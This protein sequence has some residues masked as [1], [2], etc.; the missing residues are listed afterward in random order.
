MTANVSTSQ[1]AEYRR[2]QTELADEI[3]PEEALAAEEAFRRGRLALW[4]VA[5]GWLLLVLV[6]AWLQGSWLEAV[7]A[8]LAGGAVVVAGL[9]L[10]AR[11]RTPYA[12]RLLL[13][14]STVQVFVGKL[15]LSLYAHQSIN[16]LMVLFLMALFWWLG[17]LLD[18]SASA[19]GRL[20]RPRWG[21]AR[22]WIFA[23]VYSSVAFVIW[24]VDGLPAGAPFPFA[25]LVAAGLAAL[26]P[27]WPGPRVERD[28]PEL[29]PDAELLLKA[30]TK[31]WL[32]QL[33]GRT[34]ALLFAVFPL[35]LVL[36]HLG[37]Q[38][39]GMQ[40]PPDAVSS[41]TAGSDR[42]TVFWYWPRAL[43]GL[44]GKAVGRY[45]T[46]ADLGNTELF[47]VPVE[48]PTVAAALAK[49]TQN[50]KDAAAFA[51]L[52]GA[53]EPFR[54][55][56]AEDLVVQLPL[57][58]SGIA[59]RQLVQGRARPRLGHPEGEE[60]HFALENAL[61][62]LT[63][64]QIERLEQQLPF[65]QSLLVACGFFSFILLWRRGGDSPAA[66]WLALCLAGTA[67]VA[68]EPYIGLYLPAMMQSLWV[69]ALQS[70][71]RG[72]LL[73]A[74]SLLE[75]LAHT[76]ATACGLLFAGVLVIFCWPPAPESRR[77]GLAILGRI[78]LV[79]L[80]LTV[81]A[82]VGLL[83]GGFLTTFGVVS[84][85][86]GGVGTPG[87]LLCAVAAVVGGAWL[88]RRTPGRSEVPELGLLAG[89]AFFCFQ[90]TFWI[91]LLPLFDETLPAWSGWVGLGCVILFALLA[92]LLIV[93][94][95]FLHLAAG[96]DLGQVLLIAVL[97]VVFEQ[98]EGLSS[99]LMAD[100][101]FAS[102]A[103]K[104]VLGLLIV[105]ALFAPVQ[106]LLERYAAYLAVPGLRKIQKAVEGSLE[107][108]VGIGDAASVREAA[109]RFFADLEVAGALLYRR[110]A[111]GRL[112]RLLG[113]EEAPAVL[114]PSERLRSHLAGQDGAVIDLA[115]VYLNLRHFFLQHELARLE[116]AT[117]GRYLLPI[118]LGNSLRGLAILPDDP[119]SRRVC[120]DLTGAE[121]GKLGLVVT[122]A[123][124][125]GPAAAE[126]R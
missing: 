71:A 18:H 41:R 43:P 103:G 13:T 46:T 78:G 31:R 111:D 23:L 108:L 119:A 90:V 58:E 61:V 47:V 21:V 67:L 44:E 37:L 114:V 97:P 88:R 59:L 34:L 68:A 69:E 121:V 126:T 83:L 2:F 102:E 33:A 30:A 100:T 77:R 105:L 76:M 22:L 7:L 20:R 3:S 112:E 53:L 123:G 82:G 12:G 65:T 73:G 122:E 109:A 55:D 45:L 36:C 51:E 70:P 1:A 72:L 81:P 96:R 62:P 14:L 17:G 32:A 4:A 38:E 10:G 26:W 116:K 85:G 107:W 25:A 63:A 92:I 15:S 125:V 48:E 87:F 80:A 101:L 52:R 91:A 79:L 11:Y 57:I 115:G 56:A 35:F 95:D 16:A 117:G 50:D 27:W 113:P 106:K 86:I 8:D 39:H 40:P 54:L 110:A 98:S 118:C 5:G 24:T 28:R 64:G 120:R 84:S 124:R 42:T 74:L 6:A 104:S 9:V 29:V 49:T 19:E 93:R 89:L 99:Y 66:R 75:G 60:I 94:R